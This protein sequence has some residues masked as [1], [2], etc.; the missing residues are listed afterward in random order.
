MKKQ[1]IGLLGIFVL[2]CTT[3]EVKADDVSS[4]IDMAIIS[5]S[6]VI[7]NN[8]P[9]NSIIALFNNSSDENDLTNYV[10]EEIS[11]ILINRR[12]FTIVER[13]RIENLER[14]HK[15]QMETGYV[16]D[17][18]ITS[19]VEKLGAQYVISCYITGSSYL[20]RLRIKTWNLRTGEIIASSIY[21]VDAIGVQLVERINENVIAP[22]NNQG[23]DLY[24][25]VKENGITIDF[26]KYN[27]MYN[28]DNRKYI[29]FEIYIDGTMYYY[30]IEYLSRE[31]NNS[32]QYMLSYWNINS[33]NN[34]ADISPM[35][36]LSNQSKDRNF[37]FSV[38]VIPA[39]TNSLSNIL[40]DFGVDRRNINNIT[41]IITREISNFNQNIK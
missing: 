24:S 8:L 14:E 29:L 1:L 17:E 4:E 41:R 32:F 5:A 15:W 21:P 13:S 35:R 33:T 28:G 37:N 9:T 31:N 16:P 38:S 19:I 22:N 26:L 10:I 36:H 27:D 2:F 7:A 23:R 25:T 12:R 34:I 39:M 11:T 20:Q 6:E 30:N 40:A 18:K 3:I